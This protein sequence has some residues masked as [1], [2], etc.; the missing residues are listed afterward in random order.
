M[1]VKQLPR[2]GAG[3]VAIEGTEPDVNVI[4]ATVDH[5]RCVMGHKYI[6]TRESRQC[7]LN[8]QLIK[9]ISCPLVCISKS[10]KSLT[11]VPLQTTL[12]LR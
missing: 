9:K 5:T 7:D 10:H 2:M 1:A 6:D 4:V 3:Y 8:L 11:R 12:L